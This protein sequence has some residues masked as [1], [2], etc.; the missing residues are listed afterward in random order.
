MPGIMIFVHGAHVQSKIHI[1]YVSLN[2][3]YNKIDT[4]STF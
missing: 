3:R 4:Y 1:K 2:V